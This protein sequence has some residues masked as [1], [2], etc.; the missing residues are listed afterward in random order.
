MNGRQPDLFQ[1]IPKAGRCG[2]CVH[3]NGEPDDPRS[4]C[5]PVGWRAPQDEPCEAWFDRAMAIAWWTSGR[6]TA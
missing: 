4:Y 5:T 3:R 2:D 1:G 6:K